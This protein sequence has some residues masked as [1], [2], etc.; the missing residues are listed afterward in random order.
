MIL[1]QEQFL[2]SENKVFALSGREETTRWG[3]EMTPTSP[4]AEA[5]PGS[6]G[7][8]SRTRQKI[9]GLRESGQ[10]SQVFDLGQS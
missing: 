9:R 1:C 4:G 7:V 5:V 6:D 8:T 10:H 2:P 3:S